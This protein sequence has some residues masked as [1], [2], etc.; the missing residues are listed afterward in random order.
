MTP[1]T[2]APPALDE[3]TA[4]RPHRLELVRVDLVGGGREV[5][6]NPGLN[7]IIGD[8]TTGKTTLVRLIRAMLGTMPNGLPPEVD[9]LQAIRGHVMLGSRAWQIYRP[10]TTTGDALVEIS[11]V[12][13]EPNREV[14]ALRLPVAR[15][16]RTY[17]TFLLD[18]LQ[19]P[20]VSVPQ[21]RTEPTGTLTPVTMTDWL[22]YC[23]ITGDEL[24]TE[25][26]GHKRQWR[27]VKR[28]WVFELAYGYYEQELAQLNAELRRVELQL[29]SL[30]NDAA[31]RARFLADTPFADT[32]VLDLQLAA[33][34]GE[35]EQIVTHRR[36]LGAAASEVPGVQEL[37]QTLLAT[38][39]R[40]A[41][42]T[43]RL[44]RLEAQITDLNDLRR[45]L[46][47][48]SA[49]LTRAIVADEWLV[50]FDFVVCPRCG[51]DIDAARTDP[52]L[53]YLCLQQPRPAPSQSQLLTE[54]DR[55]ASQISETDEVIKSRHR[56]QESL[57]REALHL[58]QL[59]TELTANLDQQ[60]Q[61]F[62]SDRATRIEHYAARQAQLESEIQRLREYAALFR[63]HEE[64]LVG[65]ETL[66]AEQERLRARIN[67]QELSQIDAEDNVLA[68]ERRI[69]EY[70]QE[71]HIPDLG[72]ELSV[73]INRKTYLPEVA[74]RTFEELS[75]QGLK[76]L[77]N[78]AHALAHH[79]V[80]IDRDLPLPGLLILDGLSANSGHEGFDLDRVRDVYRLL[81]QVAEQYRGALQVIAID[82]E[83]ARNILLEF[84]D[85]V[86]LTLTQEDRLIRIPQTPST[87]LE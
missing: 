69:L 27:D 33:R 9:H 8:I 35:L 3:T 66:E 18:Q 72:Q 47:S 83:L 71:L 81:R 45:Q 52:H 26:F 29:A 55:I 39:T 49:R 37:R 11:E 70:L 32:G 4:P 48:Q 85:H 6:F 20:A 36:N 23:I 58:D 78:I 86:V 31:I 73:K 76:T 63:R 34:L 10:R 54:Q 46:S 68:L 24:D 1:P 77:V 15:S 17:S 87:T 79:T 74:G 42:V 43:D 44:A 62:V 60:T 61:A 80:A 12:H 14:V 5:G 21:A 57:H 41:E 7:L 51:N 67:S 84:V 56:A 30:E 59:I 38:R 65:R 53:C 22:G 82:N 25:V 28:R 50:D 64:Q 16:D 2:S 40:R 75:S 13:P 19:I